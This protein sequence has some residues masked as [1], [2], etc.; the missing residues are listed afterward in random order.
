MKG[1][2]FLKVTGILMIIGSAMVVLLGVI[3]AGFG[4][5]VA[6]VGAASGLT[7]NYFLALL[8]TLV[9]GICQLVAGIMGVKHCKNPQ[10][11]KL[12]IIWGVL[13]VLFGIQIIVMNLYN[14]GFDSKALMSGLAGLV[15]PGLYIYGAVL[16]FRELN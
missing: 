1:S 14:G 6:G 9:G 4:A 5:L 10:K 3:V 16:N 15:I 2:K 8:A 7:G 13:V 12:L 11:A